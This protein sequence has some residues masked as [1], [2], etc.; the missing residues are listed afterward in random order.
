MNA[1]ERPVLNLWEQCLSA[2]LRLNPKENDS[3]LSAIKHVSAENNTLCIEAAN[4]F[5]KEL[6]LCDFHEAFLKIVR[7]IDPSI[8]KISIFAPQITEEKI[9]VPELKRPEKAKLSVF[10]KKY[11]LD[12]FIAETSNEFALECAKIISAKPSD[13]N[14]LVIKGTEGLGKTHLLHAIG[15]ASAKW[16]KKAILWDAERFLK[17]RDNGN[18]ALYQADILLFDNLQDLYN[19]NNQEFSQKVQNELLNILKTLKNKG[20]S[21][22][23]AL[24]PKSKNPPLPEF[25]SFLKMGIKC[26]I[27]KPDL[28]T[29][30]AILR[31][32]AQEK[33][34]PAA[35]LEDCWR[36]IAEKIGEN[37]CS[38]EGII[39][40][41]AA[42]QTH[43][44]CEITP[45]ILRSIYGEKNTNGKTPTM[46]SIATAAALA[47]NIPMETLCGKG[48]MAKVSK[49]R[50]IAIYLCKQT[51]LSLSEIGKFFNRDA[52]SIANAIQTVKNKIA[53]KDG[54]A[55]E[56]EIADI[57]NAA[58]K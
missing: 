32:K 48:R 58:R 11:K 39:N 41:L 30:I 10:C 15:N 53:G 54:Y 50:Q 22:V 14:F 16:A 24:N 13:D 37:V 9:E 17:E 38:L 35:S 43:L 2:F 25:D 47:Y 56:F 33:G 12:N 7:D 46:K 21:I 3:W 8:N 27:K 5:A 1:A 26:E 31:Q 52:S 51:G 42:R 18:L 19:L 34:L 55:Y 57:L 40:E 23:I 45:Q 28:R 44:K 6:F 4:E 29:R 20:R 49:P 36:L